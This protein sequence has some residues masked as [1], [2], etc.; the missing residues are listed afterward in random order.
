M[1]M[2][3]KCFPMCHLLGA[4][5]FSFLQVRHF[6]KA[7]TSSYDQKK[8]LGYL[9]TLT[10]RFSRLEKCSTLCRIATAKVFPF[11]AHTPFLDSPKQQLS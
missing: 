11:S 1:W 9:S 3:E 10:Q 2:L 4:H 6:W 8:N 5:C 7:T